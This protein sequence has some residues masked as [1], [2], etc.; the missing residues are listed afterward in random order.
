MST[1]KVPFNGLLKGGQTIVLFIVLPCAKIPTVLWVWAETVEE[2]EPAIGPVNKKE[3]DK[4]ATA[5]RM[6]TVI[7]FGLFVF[8]LLSPFLITG[9]RETD[10]IN[11]P[12]SCWQSL[13]MILDSIVYRDFGFRPVL[14]LLQ[15]FRRTY[16]TLT[17]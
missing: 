8:R 4:I 6:T 1:L 14:A 5:V 9:Q 13:C 12:N 3:A 15:L 16:F 10:F 7:A 2:F 17:Q 11:A